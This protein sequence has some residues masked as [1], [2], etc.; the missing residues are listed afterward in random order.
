MRLGRGP[1][2]VPLRAPDAHY[3]AKR[4]SSNGSHIYLGPIYFHHHETR[5]KFVRSANKPGDC[6]CQWPLTPAPQVIENKGNLGLHW[7][8]RS[9]I[10]C[11]VVYILRGKKTRLIRLVTDVDD[12]DS[13]L[14]D[15]RNGSPDEIS[16]MFVLVPHSDKVFIDAFKRRFQYLK[17]HGGWYR[18]DRHVHT[19]FKAEPSR[20]SLL[21]KLNSRNIEDTQRQRL[22]YSG[23]E[24]LYGGN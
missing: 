13:Y 17:S 5:Y 22:E 18:F 11:Q 16:V 2:F 24:V 20:P 12:M 10:M 7:S 8:P 9:A 14:R 3:I 1:F 21:N 6:H 4:L 23:E 19:L 15:V